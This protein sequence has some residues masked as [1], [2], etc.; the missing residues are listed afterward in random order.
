MPLQGWVSCLGGFFRRAHRG[1]LQEVVRTVM[2]ET[3][4][5]RQEPERPRCAVHL[6]QPRDAATVGDAT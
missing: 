4:V 1:L 2:S 5:R 6:Q 3:S